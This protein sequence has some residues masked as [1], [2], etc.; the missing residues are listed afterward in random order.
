MK[1]K[2]VQVELFHRVDED[3]AHTLTTWVEKKPGLKK[4]SLITLEEY[5]GWVWNVIHFYNEEHEFD[6]FDFH[7]KWDNNNYDR[8]T[9]SIVTK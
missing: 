7:R 4:G 5:P 2:I 1:K 6:D 8:H 3:H 9:G